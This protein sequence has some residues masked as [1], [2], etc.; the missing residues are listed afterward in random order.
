MTSRFNPHPT[1]RLGAIPAAT[2]RPA[3][4]GRFNPHPTRRLG[5][6]G[7]LPVSGQCLAGVSI[8]TQPEGWVP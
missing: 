8:L 4:F 6:M 1:R 5:A 7:N 3:Y 2:K